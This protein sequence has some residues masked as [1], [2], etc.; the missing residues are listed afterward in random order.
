MSYQQNQQSK[1]EIGLILFKNNFKKAPKEPDMT[2][3]LTFPDGKEMEVSMWSKTGAGDEN[4]LAGNV[5]DK[6][7]K[8]EGYV[9]K[10]KRPQQSQATAP[11]QNRVK[12]DF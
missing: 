4:Y 12:I 6:W 5:K 10:S 2:G 7:I 11:V 3:S 8:P 1:N 9:S